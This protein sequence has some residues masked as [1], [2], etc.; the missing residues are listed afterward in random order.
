MNTSK[1]SLKINLEKKI[2]NTDKKVVLS[3]F[4]NQ[5]QTPLSNTLTKKQE[6]QQQ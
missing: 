5:E 2:P 1:K 4:K 6:Q 3:V